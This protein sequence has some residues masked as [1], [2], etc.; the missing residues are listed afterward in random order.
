M[1]LLTDLT[2]EL[3]VY[4]F[5]TDWQLIMFAKLVFHIGITYSKFWSSSYFVLIGSITIEAGSKE[6]Q[7]AVLTT[8]V[9][10]ERHPTD[11]TQTV[12]L[13]SRD[14][15]ATTIICTNSQ[16]QPLGKCPPD[17]TPV[18]SEDPPLS[19]ENAWTLNPVSCLWISITITPHSKITK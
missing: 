13:A 17:T 8:N 3:A 4:L 12:H 1:S 16:L 10:C 9:K 14:Y 15:R 6:K 2:G 18:W 7:A 5:S 19:M 11:V